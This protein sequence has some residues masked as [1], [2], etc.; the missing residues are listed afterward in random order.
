[1][2]RIHDGKEAGVRITDKGKATVEDN[3][4]H[5]NS[6]ACVCMSKAKALKLR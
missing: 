2:N 3:D 6:L 1:M 5:S 4:I